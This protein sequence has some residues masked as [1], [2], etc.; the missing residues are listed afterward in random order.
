MADKSVRT[1]NVS[2]TGELL[3]KPDIAIVGLTVSTRADTAAEAVRM[4]AQRSQQVNE[5]V[6][7]LAGV[8]K[9][10][11][12]T[13]GIRVAPVTRYDEAT[14]RSVIEGYEAENTVAVTVPVDLAGAVFDAGI[15]AGANESSGITF[16]LENEETARMQALERAIAQ[17]RRKAEAVARAAGVK[18]QPPRAINVEGRFGPVFE[19]VAM[20]RYDAEPADVPTPIFPG[21]LRIVA[22]VSVSYGFEP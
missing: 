12:R 1:L 16:Q 20:A 5:R 18:L 7:A 17:A 22:N 6:G 10:S 2:G 19:K 15:A 13:T 9:E 14:R 11:I 21:E 4:N 3:V 8:D